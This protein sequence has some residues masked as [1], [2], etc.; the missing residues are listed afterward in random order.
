MLIE[1]TAW[2]CPLTALEIN[3]LQ[4]AGEVGYAGGFI[5]RYLIQLLYPVEITNA[6]QLLLGFAVFVTNVLV[7]MLVRRRWQRAGRDEG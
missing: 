3:W 4:A 1:F 2:P 6:V 5:E 7:Y